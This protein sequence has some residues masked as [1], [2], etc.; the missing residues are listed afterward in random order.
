M[1][2]AAIIATLIAG[3]ETKTNNGPVSPKDAKIGNNTT[4]VITKTPAKN[5]A[6]IICKS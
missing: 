3:T 4:A 2:K 1:D 6:I 5:L